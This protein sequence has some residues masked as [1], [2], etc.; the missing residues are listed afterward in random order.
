MDLS[1]LFNFNDRVTKDTV[2]VKDV[3]GKHDER[4]VKAGFNWLGG[5]FTWFYALFSQKYKTEG[6]IKKTAVPFVIG[7]VVNL[8]LQ[9][10]NYAL[11]GIANIAELV[12]FG[13][14]FDTWFRNQLLANGYIEEGQFEETM[15][16]D[17]SLIECPNCH[18]T[19]SASTKFC[20]NCG[21]NIP[22]LLKEQK[23]AE[24]QQSEVI[25]P[26]CQTSN[27][28]GAKFCVNCGNDLSKPTDKECPECQTKVALDGKFCPN[29][30]H[31]FN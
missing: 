2:M 9:E 27:Q 26:K 16:D 6:F 1:D 29:C 25:C 10:I 15:A 7:I 18:S 30:G 8:I 19:I 14:M 24:K 22:E 5:L 12:W 4:E 17:E 11:Y 21:A 28:L 20:T 13:F 23:E 3:D 31:A